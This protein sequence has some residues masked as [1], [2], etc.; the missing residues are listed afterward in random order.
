MNPEGVFVIG[1]PLS[2]FPRLPVRLNVEVLSSGFAIT[3]YAFYQLKTWGVLAPFTS[4]AECLLGVIGEPS[5][6]STGVPKLFL[7]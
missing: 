2:T 7:W 5:R 6:L 4:T 1:E 3:V